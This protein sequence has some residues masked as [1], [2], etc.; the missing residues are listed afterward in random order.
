MGTHENRKRLFDE[1]HYYH[2]HAWNRAPKIHRGATL[3]DYKRY[4]A[5]RMN[6]WTLLE[7]EF[8]EYIRGG[9]ATC[10]A[11]STYLP[12]TISSVPNG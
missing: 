4:A 3:N 5:W 6:W 1:L 9:V 10:T 12:D 2:A 8:P 11:R 7:K